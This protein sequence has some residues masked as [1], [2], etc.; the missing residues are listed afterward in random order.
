MADIIE[1]ILAD[2]MRMRRL[3]AEMETALGRADDN[4]SRAEMP[5][6]WETL[7]ELLEVHAAAIEEIGFLPLFGR[8]ATPARDNAR[9]TDDD[10]LEA[11][12]ETRLYPAGSRSWQLAVLAACA[13]AADHINDLES[14][15]LARFRRDAPI[16]VRDALGRQW[17]A[18]VAA[19]ASRDKHRGPF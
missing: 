16:P 3:L 17:M 5:A 14:G 6:R 18:F 4:G 2:H 19:N 12:R 15:A 8:T 11:V 1:L 9:A 10:I 13:A 7:A